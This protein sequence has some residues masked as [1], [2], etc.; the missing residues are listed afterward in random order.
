MNLA[1]VT[2]QNENDGDS[3]PGNGVDTDGDGVAHFGK[4]ACNVGDPFGR[5][6]DFLALERADPEQIMKTMPALRQAA[7]QCTDADAFHLKKL[8]QQVN[9]YDYDLAMETIRN[10][11]RDRQEDA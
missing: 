4:H 10:I 5:V 1:E 2:A 9:R 6:G 8:E 11:R 3:T 7:A